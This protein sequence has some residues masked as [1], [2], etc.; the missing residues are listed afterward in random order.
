MFYIAL[1]FFFIACVP[2]NS[3]APYEDSYIV[4]YTFKSVK[5][6]IIDN[7]HDQGNKLLIKYIPSA[8][9]FLIYL[10]KV[11][12]VSVTIFRISYFD[13]EFLPIFNSSN[14]QF[15]LG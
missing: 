10:I 12:L 7:H 1:L 11:M 14:L 8:R 15:K 2:T 5:L 6:L 13:F 9:I 3:L 4:S